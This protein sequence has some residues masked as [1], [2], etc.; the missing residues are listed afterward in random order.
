MSCAPRTTALRRFCVGLFLL[1][2]LAIGGYSAQSSGSESAPSDVKLRIRTLGGRSVFQ[3][4]EMIE[5]ELLFTSSAPKKYL[6]TS[7]NPPRPHSLDRVAISPL[8]G[9]DDPIGDF[10]RFCSFFLEG[11]LMGTQSLS[12]KP[13]IIRLTLNDWVRFKDP[14]EYQFTVQS[15]RA[16]TRSAMRSFILNSNRLS[17]TIIPANPQWQEQ[18]LRN[19]VKVLDDTGSFADL[20]G[21]RWRARWQ[22]TDTL[23]FLGTVGAAHEMA[24]WLNSG[25][26]TSSGSFLVGLAI[27]PEREVALDEMK[28]LLVDPKFPVYEPDIC[29]MSLL[30]LGPDRTAQTSVEQKTLQD[31]FRD[32]LRSALKNKQGRALEVSTA[33][34]NSVR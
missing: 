26:L 31:R 25:D 20:T 7:F 34:A 8:S 1:Y 4:G 29:A 9:W 19:A 5:L 17:I 28:A 30:A 32:E 21:D 3:I 15:D 14:G 33:T 12:A 11:G 6:V 24:R 18:T 22:A 2:A 16:G 13:T 27:S 23:R 10:F